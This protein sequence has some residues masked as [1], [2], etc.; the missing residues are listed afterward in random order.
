MGRDISYLKCAISLFNSH[1]VYVEVWMFCLRLGQAQRTGRFVESLQ[2]GQ[3]IR[4]TGE[5]SRQKSILEGD[6]ESQK[7]ISSGRKFIEIL[8]FRGF[9]MEDRD[10][11]ELQ[12]HFCSHYALAEVHDQGSHE[13]KVLFKL[14]ETELLELGL[15]S[16]SVIFRFIF[17]HV[18]LSK[19]LSKSLSTLFTRFFEEQYILNYL[20]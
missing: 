11:S 15:D 1:D 7:Q 4:R 16:F 17:C 2:K 12:Y 20:I 5:N 9:T 18:C 19:I 8:G 10:N 13:L 3:P 14:R 6:R